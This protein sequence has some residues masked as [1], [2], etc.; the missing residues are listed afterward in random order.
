M[1]RTAFYDVV[2]KELGALTQPQ[3]TGFEILLT[4]V[5]GLPDSHQAYLLATAWHETGRTMQ[6]VREAHGAT[7]GQTIARL[8]KA[9]T[10]GRLGKVKTPYWRKD[11]DGKAWFGRGY[12]QLTHRANYENAGKKLG[13]D[14]VAD[15]SAVLSPM[16]AA[17]ILVAGC[18]QGWFT[19]KQL[20]DYL[21]GDYVNARRVVNGLD[22]AKDIALYAMTFER[23]LVAAEVTA[24]SPDVPVPTVVPQ[25]AAVWWWAAFW[26][27][28]DQFTRK[29]RT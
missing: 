22:C 29:W 17:K 28:V 24:P 23:A 13:I 19:G 6:P 7:D 4:A 15:P 11:A 25:P 10:A 16:V 5:N 9:W 12:V 21:P 26:K 3:V 20:S 1:N 8:D 2:R 14:L 18:S 27:I